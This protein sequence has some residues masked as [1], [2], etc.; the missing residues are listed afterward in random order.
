[1]EDDDLQVAPEQSSRPTAIVAAGPNQSLTK[2]DVNGVMRL[3]SASWRLLSWPFKGGANRIV[4]VVGLAAIIYAV[5]RLPPDF[6]DLQW[7]YLGA[8]RRPL[9]WLLKGTGVQSLL[10]ALSL[11]VGYGL[12]YWFFFIRKHR[13]IV[14][15]EFRVWGNLKKEFP[16]KGV[17]ARLRDELLGLW[18]AIISPE[19]EEPQGRTEPRIPDDGSLS[20]PEAH[21]TLQY[22]GISLEALNTFVRR[23]TGREVVITGDLVSNS[24]GL[25]LAARTA[26]LGPWEVVVEKQIPDPLP[27]G[28]ERLAIKIMTAMTKR[29]QPYS[30]RTF[31]LLQIKAREVQDYNEAFRLAKL[32]REV[33]TDID[34]ANWNLATAHHDL[35]VELA[36][37]GRVLEAINDFRKATELNPEFEEAHTSLA[38]AYELVGDKRSAQEAF[39]KAEQLKTREFQSQT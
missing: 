14:V 30:A 26:D 7:P 33:A 27:L 1:M 20:L 23:L 17:A 21:V 13:F 4:F 39:Q 37:S 31:A 18:N 10:G 3:V 25:L 34:T 5:F 35:G 32:G 9:F 36:N 15:A 12:L 6:I 19:P 29:F 11:L 8:L 38:N 24:T 28:L 16:D 2:R 22:E